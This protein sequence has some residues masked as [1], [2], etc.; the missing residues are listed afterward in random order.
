[1]GGRTLTLSLLLF[2]VTGHLGKVIESPSRAVL[3]KSRGDLEISGRS[4]FLILDIS[5]QG[6]L[7][8]IKPIGEAIANVSEGLETELQNLEQLAPRRSSQLPDIEQHTVN[9]SHSD[10]YHAISLTLNSNMRQHLR[11]LV[12]DLEKQHNDLINFLSTL[13][14]TQYD[15]IMGHPSRNT[16]GLIDGGG[17]ILHWLLGIA[18][19]SQV[20][21][22]NQLLDKINSLSEETR[23]MV[24]IHSTILNTTAIQFERVTTQVDR[25]TTCLGQI[26]GA[27]KS[28]GS[29]I[30]TQAIHTFSVVHSIIMSNSLSYASSAISDLAGQF[31]NLKIGLSKFR[32]GY[33]S[34]E[35]IPPD[36]ILDLVNVITK[37]NLKPIYPSTPK[38][39]PL[40]YQYIKVHTL[41]VSPLTFLISIP[42]EGD[43]KVK[44]ELFEVLSLPH[45]ITPDL[46]LTYSNLPRFIAVSDDRRKYLELESIDSCRHHS[47]AYLCPIDYP[48]YRDGA[49][50]CALNLLKG[51]SDDIC[52]KHF[53]GALARPILTKTSVGW[54]YSFSEP[55]TISVT[56]PHNSSIIHISRGSGRLKTQ[57]HCK[58]SGN[59]FTL[60]SSA[61]SA[62]P[63]I[64]V[65]FS[66][67][68]PFA[69]DLSESEIE[70]LRVLNS[71]EI[72]TNIMVLNG[73]KL[74]LKSLKSEIKNLAYI[75]KMRQ[76]NSIT[77]NAGL[78][79]S[80]LSFIG[81]IFIFIII[82]VFCKVAHA[83]KKSGEF[84]KIFKLLQ[85]QDPREPP[86][87]LHQ[88]CRERGTGIDPIDG[89]VLETDNIQVLYRPHTLPRQLYQANRH[90]AAISHHS[91]HAEDLELDQLSTKV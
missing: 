56:C 41:E 49:P 82:A 36:V 76:I 86:I 65:N 52:S 31:L 91:D 25:V 61:E 39:L 59:K 84:S 28:L 7:D 66:I 30:Q 3:F 32:A 24:N 85:K 60:P 9:P 63:P 18:T 22:T 83:N 19:D 62:G 45:P 23:T 8:S 10:P 50:S 5:I 71:S 16:R 58:I 35:I 79:F 13:S 90:T 80:I 74:P 72:L 2:V 81:V 6:L 53:S 55:D 43:P 42:L 34:P 70:K 46:T 75:K 29:H 64:T 48:I 89:T 40:L 87:N 15:P 47:N 12:A 17:Q 26:R 37:K 68:S 88:G 1:M 51:L 4:Y 54:L 33:I 14:K 78:A 38:F 11:F 44:L 21:N 27:I 57:N 73:N 67:V 69:V 77:G 20:E